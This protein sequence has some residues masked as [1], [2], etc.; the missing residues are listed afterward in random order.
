MVDLRVVVSEGEKSL[1][2][3]VPAA[4]AASLYG[5]KMGDSVDG[6]KLG[7]KG[8]ELKITGGTD[9]DG[10]PMRRDLPA[11]GKRRLLLSRG[12]GMQE[13]GKG[14]RRKKTV[15]G[16]KV[17]KDIAQLNLKVLKSGKE[18]LEKLMG[19]EEAGEGGG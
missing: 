11:E 2:K 10:F 8:Y 4:E 1:Q 12:V 19:G 18:P 15:H 17:G 16:A 6:G 3:V 5:L 14:M 7:L 9:K 13:K